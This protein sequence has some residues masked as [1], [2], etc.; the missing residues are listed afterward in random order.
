MGAESFF[1]L[2]AEGITKLRLASYDRPIVSE[3]HFSKDQTNQLRKDLV[4]Y[5]QTLKVWYAFS[6]ATYL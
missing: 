2:Q 6:F 4:D 1:T 3:P 5:L